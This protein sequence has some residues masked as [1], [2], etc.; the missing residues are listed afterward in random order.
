MCDLRRFHPIG[1]LA[2]MNARERA[3]ALF[4]R[5]HAL[6][7]M[8][9]V[10]ALPGTPYHR[11]SVDSIIT[12]AVREA[13]MLRDGGF[14]AILIEN[15]HDR[16]YLAQ[17]VGPEIVAAMT[18]I[19]VAVREAVDLPL[20]VQVLGAANREALAVAL[21]LGARFIRAENFAY[22]HVADEGLMA[23]ADAGPLLRYRRAIGAE[24]I[25]VLADVKK[26]HAS[27]AITADVDIAEAARTAAFFGADGIVVTGVATGRATQ[28]E[29]VKTVWQAVELPVLIG[30]GTTPE[31]I[32]RYWPH[33]NA[34]IVGSFLKEQ[35]V[36]SNPPDAERI[37]AIVAA[38]DALR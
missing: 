12:Q 33:A 18:A 4:G 34:F 8:I 17:Q 14:D 13:V 19:G 35:G 20:G 6:V 32:E 21:A 24:G 30:S 5:D 23:T 29:D 31:N 27:H 38:A 37:H 28:A 26:K 22:A 2:G 36:W 3:A 15:M 11:D 10:G 9:H 1:K 7:G 25:A 16:P